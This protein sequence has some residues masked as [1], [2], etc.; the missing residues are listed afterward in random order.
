MKKLYYILAVLTTTI[1]VGCDKV[2]PTGILIGGTGVDDRVL[3][4]IALHDKG[5]LG[6]LIFQVPDSDY[7]VLVGAD[8][9]ILDDTK[10]LA[11][12]HEIGYRD[13]DIFL[14]H[15]GDLA[16]TQADPYLLTLECVNKYEEKYGSHFFPVVGNHDITHN[17]FT[18]F[19][20]IFQSSTYVV[21][22]L[23]GDTGKRDVF[24]FMDTAAGT[25][26]TKQIEFFERC[27]RDQCP[28]TTI[29]NIYTFGHTNY[30]RNTS[31][32]L[33]FSSTIPRDELYYMLNWNETHHVKAAVTGHVHE[34][35]HHTYGSVEYFNLDAISERN[36]PMP[37]PYLFR[38]KMHKNGDF[39]WDRV[40]M[41]SVKMKL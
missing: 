13:G 14:A 20:M 4:S 40:Q 19:S 23:I 8:S 36:N 30:F 41:N 6:D 37:G 27:M 9:H 18:Y 7:T 3:Q 28:G 12:M 10:R 17:G 11:E 35:D 21:N 16:D 33:E 29:R 24:L 22:V 26:G 25:L 1:M 15:L 34:F 31:G 2:S 39:S 32:N 38:M 5:Y